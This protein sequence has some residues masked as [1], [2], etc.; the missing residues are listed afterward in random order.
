M[1]CFINHLGIVCR[2]INYQIMGFILTLF[3][4]KGRLLMSSIYCSRRNYCFCHLIGVCERILLYLILP[5]PFVCS[6]SS[7][8][9]I[10]FIIQWFKS[11][12]FLLLNFFSTMD[13]CNIL[14]L[15][16]TFSFNSSIF[17]HIAHLKLIFIYNNIYFKFIYK[18]LK[19]DGFICLIKKFK[20]KVTKFVN[21][22]LLF[23]NLVF[24]LF[25][26]AYWL[27]IRVI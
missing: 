17:D 26:V 23:S 19:K 10:Q 21:N 15:N 22:F 7:Y 11:K 14:F 27:Y 1:S 13:S 25:P 12:A 6:M 24:I 18:K 2:N 16:Y 4:R 5:Q 8:L 9:V 3:L 20:A